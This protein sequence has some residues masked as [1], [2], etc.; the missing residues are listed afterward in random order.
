MGKTILVTGGAGYIG[1]HAVHELLLKGYEPVILDN[2]S[3]GHRGFTQGCEIIEC[4]LRDPA[5]TAKACGHRTFDAV[6]HFA[7]M[8]IVGDSVKDPISYFE[9]NVAGSVNLIKA[10]LNSGVQSFVFSS[11]AAVYG[12]PQA[13]TIDEQHPVNPVNP[14][15]RSKLMVESILS[16]V[17]KANQFASISFR[18]F[19]AAGAV[20]DA[21][22]GENHSPETHLI[23]NILNS[24]L[25]GGSQSLNVFGTDYDTRDG[26][27]VRDYIHVSDLARA[28][29]LG[30]EY[31]QNHGGCEA[32]NLGTQ[33]GSSV[34]EVIA[35][36]EASTGLTIPYGIKGRRAGDPATLIADNKKAL[37]LINW[38]P[39]LTLD[40]CVEDAW[41]WHQLRSKRV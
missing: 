29:V 3:T 24:C 26:S 22:L 21:S 41:R 10:A 30:L 38:S 18:Y 11:T 6:M 32:V 14:Y 31:V 5:S 27:C 16:E 19:N 34:L 33:A 15:G 25:A 1:S 40:D 8:S 35:A 12:E 4:D 37:E 23:P 20:E 28:H 36:C 39:Q 13:E 2:F 17:Y 9:N 7:A